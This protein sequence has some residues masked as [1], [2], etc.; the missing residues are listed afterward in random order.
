[1]SLVYTIVTDFGGAVDVKSVVDEGSTFSIYI[2]LA[3]SIAEAVA[4]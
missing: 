2:P 3:D 1:M 4:A